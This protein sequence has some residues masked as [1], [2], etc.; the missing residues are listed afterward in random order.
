VKIKYLF[1]RPQ[2]P[3]IC[4][5]DNNL[6]AARN[7]SMFEKN[8]EK[9]ELTKEYYPVILSNSTERNYSINS[10]IFLLSFAKK[11]TKQ[12]LI[13]LYNNSNDISEIYK[14]RSISVKR[15]EA[16]FN[17]IVELLIK[18]QKTRRSNRSGT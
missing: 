15:F 11:Y 7:M 3:V 4:N 8:L 1:G 14:G 5:I 2:F 16:I 17:E 13:D 12:Q 10:K 18:R 9:F 6:F